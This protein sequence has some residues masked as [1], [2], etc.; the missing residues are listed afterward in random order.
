V[1]IETA[2]SAGLRVVEEFVHVDSEPISRAEV[3]WLDSQTL[4]RVASTVT[5]QPNIAVVQIPVAAGLEQLDGWALVADRVQDPGNLGTMIRS[6]VAAGASAIVTTPHTVDVLSPKVVRAAAGSLFSIPLI[7]DVPLE[8][9]T[10]SGF[11][12]VGTSSHDHSGAVDYDVFDFTGHIALVM[13]NEAAGLSADTPVQK[14]VSIPHV[15][16]VESLNV[17]MASTVL[18]F[19]IARQRKAASGKSPRD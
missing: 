9:L 16:P 13:G 17:A 7:P 8:E 1:F 12:L 10:A 18:C 11:V 19:E 4:E 5:P 6:A 3:Y 2:L 15:G 14:W